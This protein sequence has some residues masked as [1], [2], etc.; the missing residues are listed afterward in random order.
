MSPDTGG[1]ST[2]KSTPKDSSGDTPQGLDPT[3]SAQ[4]QF[5]K[6]TAGDPDAEERNPPDG[7]HVIEERGKPS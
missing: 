7:P 2:S 4:S 1:T 5:A 3:L 6:K